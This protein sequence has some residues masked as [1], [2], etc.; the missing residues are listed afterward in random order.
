VRWEAVP[1]G[2]AVDRVEFL[3]DRRLREAVRQPPFVFAGGAWQ[4]WREP[5]G[6]R[7]LTVRAVTAA[8]AA[9]SSSVVVR[10]ANPPPTVRIDDVNLVEGQTVTGLVRIEAAITGTLHR[11]EF[12]VDGTVRATV[13][14]APFAFDW[15]TALDLPGPRRIT[16]RA[17][18]ANG[19]PTT[20][21]VTVV[22]TR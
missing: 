17:I 13:T 20:R 4:T 10:I 18:A 5:N 16:V 3:V 1:A 6:R 15:D 11:V 9:V 2:A 22:V 14:A 12:L 19:R 7:V 8:G 21:N